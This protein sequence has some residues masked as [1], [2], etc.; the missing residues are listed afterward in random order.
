L[1]IK[2]NSAPSFFAPETFLPD[3]EIACER[4]FAK[5]NIL[6]STPEQPTPPQQ[7]SREVFVDRVEAYTRDEPVKALS[8][9]FG[10]GILLTLLP[11]GSLVA[12]VT[13]LLFLVARPLLL[14]LGLVKLN[15]EWQAR[16]PR[17]GGEVAP[18]DNDEANWPPV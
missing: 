10:V 13:R 14:I 12:A 11:I 15:E 2:K 17:A 4:E 5:K 7:P 8:A 3:S 16:R 9:A 18:E 1:R 6:M